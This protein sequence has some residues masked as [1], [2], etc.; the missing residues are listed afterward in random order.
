[1]NDS[2]KLNQITTMCSVNAHHQ[3]GK[4]ERRIRQLQDMLRTSLLH[5]GTL[6]KYAINVHLWPYDLRESCDDINHVPHPNSTELPLELFAQVP[7][8]N[9]FHQNHTFGCPVFVLKRPLQSGIKI[10]K[11]DPRATM[12]IYLD[13]SFIHASSVGLILSL[14]TVLVSP[15]FHN[16]DDDAFVTVSE[17]F[18]KYIPMSQWQVKCGF[19]IDP[20]SAILSFDHNRS[21]GDNADQMNNIQ[22]D[23]NI[24]H[25]ATIDNVNDN[26]IIDNEDT[27][28]DRINE[29]T[30]ND[31]INSTVDDPTNIES[32]PNNK[33]ERN[34]AA[35]NTTTITRSGRVSR[36]PVRYGDY[37]R[38]TRLNMIKKN[39]WNHL[40]VSQHPPIRM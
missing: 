34:P 19:Q 24:E 7:I 37:I 35:D 33:T 8:N 26:Q 2:L 39:M 1:M 3:N 40:Y 17:S 28:L 12:G 6:W 23:N 10:P 32:I 36:R 21:E 18:G 5:A 29:S 13:P 25:D 9:N 38:I 16:Q 11:W 14:R 30:I 31:K 4:V 20:S 22:N 15:S 27:I